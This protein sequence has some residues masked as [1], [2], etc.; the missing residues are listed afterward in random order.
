MDF[1]KFLDENGINYTLRH[2]DGFRT[3]Y[4]H[5][6]KIMLTDPLDG[7]KREFTSYLRVSHFDGPDDMWYTRDCGICGWK[8]INWVLD[9]CKKLGQEYKEENNG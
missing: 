7:T 9:E 3:V 2:D 5:G 1:I 6:R 8:P 4:I